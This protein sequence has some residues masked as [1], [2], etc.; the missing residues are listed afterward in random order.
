[1]HFLEYGKNRDGYWAAAGFSKQ[2]DDLSDGMECLH[3]DWQ[4]LVEVDWSSGHSAHCSG[5]LSVHTMN[6]NYG[7]K[8]SIPTPSVVTDGCLGKEDGR[9]LQP[10]DRQY[11]HFR[12][13]AESGDGKPDPPP[14]YASDLPVEKYFGQAK[15]MKQ[16]LGSAAIGRRE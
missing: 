11:F 9:C 4:I 2:L 15:G 5:C 3:P 14:F 10:R 16:V 6:V 1:M 12:S 8:Q 13:A 7:G